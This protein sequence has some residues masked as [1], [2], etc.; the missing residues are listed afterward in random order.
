MNTDVETGFAEKL[1][2]EGGVG[3]GLKLGC[4]GAPKAGAGVLAAPKS[5]GALGAAPVAGE[6][7]AAGAP[8]PKLPKVCV[9][10]GALL[11]GA[12]LKVGKAFGA[13]VCAPKVGPLAAGAGD[14]APKVNGAAG[15]LAAPPLAPNENTAVFVSAFSLDAN[16]LP[17]VVMALA[18]PNVRLGAAMLEEGAGLLAGAA[19]TA[20]PNAGTAE[21]VE[22]L[23]PNAEKA[24][25]DEP[26]MGA[27][28]VLAGVPKPPRGLL[29][30]SA[31]G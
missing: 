19:L 29:A 27:A 7:A 22:L 15:L 31:D 28:G 23:E 25:V 24:F 5:D 26:N 10:A 13:E 12:A 4:V 30:I 3:F 18:V 6:G 11:E 2:W 1:N 16:E 9:A 21:A 8:A 20:A 17:K 14:G